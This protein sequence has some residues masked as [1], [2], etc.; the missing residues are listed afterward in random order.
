M[1]INDVGLAGGLGVGR[2]PV[3][4]AVNRLETD[5]LV[6]TC[7]TAELSPSHPA[8][9]VHVGFVGSSPA[10][11]SP[12]PQNQQVTTMDQPGTHPVDVDEYA[13]W[14]AAALARETVTRRT[15][16]KA[17]AGG[18]GGYALAQFTLA[19]AAFAAGGGTPGTGGVVISG[20]H[21]SFVQDRDGRPE[22]A[23]AVAAQLVSKAGVLPRRLR[24]Y[25][26]V[27]TQAGRY[28][29]R[30]EA[31][32]VHLVG[33]YAI[34]GGPVGSQ[35]YVKAKITG[36]RPD[37]LHHYRLRLSDGATSG[38]A[39]FTTAPRHRVGHHQHDHDV[40]APFTFTAFADV[41]TNNAPT[42]P[43]YAWGQDPAAVTAAGGTWPRSV[44]DNNYY[45]TTD[46]VGGTNGTDPRPAATQTN[47]MASQRPVFTLLAGDIC[48]A[49]PSGSGLPADDSGAL[50]GGAKPGTNL[51]NPYVWDVFLNQIESQA[52]FTPWMFATGN[53]DMEAL[54]GRTEFLGDSP[55]HGY[56]G[57]KVRL[58]LPANGPKGCP[59][60]YQFV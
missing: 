47:L 4:E 59:S 60:V 8:L 53:H 21:L 13:E 28:G 31:E 51:F 43:R 54:Y 5:H 6:V 57:H 22:S 25:V 14:N 3:R 48:Y 52:A 9:N 39:Y 24:A 35:F 42:D 18:A 40:A 56:G 29:T 7:C 45:A 30:I 1:P 41:G 33:Q 38:D 12:G 26:E 58:D 37:S 46:P 50:G 36:L 55:N 23:M 32:I 2:T 17:V 44:F 16:L 10:D 27:G 34:P 49:D 19:N 11:R 15:V 20:R